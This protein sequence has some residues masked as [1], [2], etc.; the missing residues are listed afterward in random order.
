MVIAIS[1]IVPLVIV[2]QSSLFAVVLLTDNGPKRISNRYLATFLLILGLQFSAITSNAFELESKFID[3]CFC[4]Y[5]FI[6]G[7]VLFFYTRSLVYRSF[8]FHPKQLWHLFPAVTVILFSLFSLSICQPPFGILFY[9]SLITY[10]SL[11]V[12]ELIAYRKVIR[13]TQSTTAKIDI[14]WLQWT[15]I[16]F[17]FILLLDILDQ[18][19]LSM[20]L[21][22][23]ISPIYLCILLLI[24]WMFYK[25]LKQPQI[26]LGITESDE[27]LVKE[28]DSTPNAHIPTEAEKTELER[29]QNFMRTNDV[30]TNAELSLN[31][32]SSML[33]LSPR[34]LSSLINNYLHQ[35]FI[36]FVNEYRIEMA[37]TKLIK[38]ADQ[39]ST[40]QEI[41]YE[42]GFNSK[43][44][45]NTIFK[46]HTG[47]T[48]S[49][50]KKKHLQ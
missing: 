45:F 24:N 48:P 36:G 28:R 6:Y 42:V 29:I 43:S 37:K 23:G 3:S 15:I 34:R 14:K 19:A 4:V 9:A 35:N 44:S 30:Y 26:F 47:L 49:E 10:I 46:Q 32:L 5:G 22:Y 21:L 17:S 8:K 40:I 18:T 1:D 33:G 2:F 20:K 13:D 11:A 50:F 31:E 38:S 12:K 7:P 39:G 25:G 41:M 27:L 16:L